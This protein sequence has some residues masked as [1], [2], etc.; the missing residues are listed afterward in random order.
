MP[1]AT[2]PHNMG[3]DRHYWETRL[4]RFID[5]ILADLPADGAVAELVELAH[6][7]DPDAME[8]IRD[9]LVEPLPAPEDV[10]QRLFEAKEAI[11]ANPEH[12]IR[13]ARKLT[14]LAL[15]PC[16]R[17]QVFGLIAFAHG[18]RRDF[19]SAEHAMSIAWATAHETGCRPCFAV[20]HRA[21]ACNLLRE[22]RHDEALREVELAIEA[23][24][25]IG[26]PGHDLYGAGLAQSLNNRGQILALM[27]KE[28]RALSDFRDALSLLTAK[29]PF[30]KHALFDYAVCLKQCGPAYY[31][32]A[33]QVLGQ[34]RGSFK[35][36][37]RRS[38]P[39]AR[40][41]WLEGGLWLEIG[42][43]RRARALERLDRAHEDFSKM[44]ME[45]E[46]TAVLADHALVLMPERT[47]IQL[48]IAAAGTVRDGGLRAALDA[49]KTAGDRVW[50]P[51][52]KA[53]TELREACQAPGV[54]PQFVTFRAN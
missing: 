17:V 3:S 8:M 46:A 15:G 43:D 20:L 16:E 18:M 25:E 40:L 10:R 22:E 4:A 7:G 28:V 53:I 41:D 29:D 45:F 5:E 54:L 33:L 23:Y 47:E 12:G 38:V 14:R 30:L 51:L 21:T 50:R 27:G 19:P 37:R 52:E 6:A 31:E 35:G 11:D 2:T 34:V 49:L 48:L 13:L 24:K 32:E 42:T 39:R 44:G 1:G 9:A 36:P 26:G